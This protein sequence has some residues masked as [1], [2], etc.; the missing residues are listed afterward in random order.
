MLVVIQ[1]RGA[2]DARWSA[3]PAPPPLPT[4]GMYDGLEP[5]EA[6]AGA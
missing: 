5:D 3:E 6:I 1:Q 4:K 2:H